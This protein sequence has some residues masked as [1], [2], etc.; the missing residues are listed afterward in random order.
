MNASKWENPRF[1]G[2]TGFQSTLWKQP[3]LVDNVDTHAAAGTAN[4]T[5]SGFDIVYDF[6]DDPEHTTED[7]TLVTVLYSLIMQLVAENSTLVMELKLLAREL[8]Y[9]DEENGVSDDPKKM[10][11]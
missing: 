7:C 9:E 11:S 4:C 10:Y 3:G 6:I 1:P 5:H 2:F 8:A